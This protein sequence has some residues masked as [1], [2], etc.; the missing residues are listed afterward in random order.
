LAISATPK[1][2]KIKVSTHRPRYIETTRVPKLAKG[3]SSAVELEY[4]APVGAKGESAEVPKA[5]GHEKTELGEAPK[6]PA[7]AKEK[8]VEELKLEESAGLPKILSPPPELE[9]PKVSKVPAITPKRRRMASVLDAVLE[10]TREPIPASA[11][12]AVEAAT[13]RAE[14]EARPSVPIEIGPVETSE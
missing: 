11:K 2:K 14:V 5:T 7:E 6:R 8:A 13:T 10:S 4:P 9:L 3:T 1:G 12:E